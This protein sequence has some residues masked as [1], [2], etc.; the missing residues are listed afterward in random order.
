M[1]EVYIRKK[2]EEV[3][4]QNNLERVG[5]KSILGFIYKSIVENFSDFSCCNLAT[6][7]N[8]ERLMAF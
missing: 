3:Q 1:F 8:I 7:L 4:S 2:T 5:G 6:F